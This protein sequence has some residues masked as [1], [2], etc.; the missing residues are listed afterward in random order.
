MTDEKGEV[1]H[2]GGLMRC[3]T[4]TWSD[5]MTEWD[6]VHSQPPKDGDTIQCKYS[7]DEWHKMIRVDG[8]WQW[9]TPL[10]VR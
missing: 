3:C 6:D 4:G 2:T 9:D 7:D 8:V 1:I 10:I 5:T